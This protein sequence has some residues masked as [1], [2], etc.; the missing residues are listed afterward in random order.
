MQCMHLTYRALDGD[1]VPNVV[2]PQLRN[3]LSQIKKPRTSSLSSGPSVALLPSSTSSTPANASSST[4][5][6]ATATAWVVSSEDQR[7]YEI[8]FRQL[9]ADGKQ[10]VSGEDVKS[11]F[12]STGLPGNILAH[13]WSLCD[14]N[15]NGN[16]TAEQFM[17][18]MHLAKQKRVSNKVVVQHCL[19]VDSTVLRL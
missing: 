7:Q 9:D 11:L 8:L 15:G 10:C 1:P 16:L 14:M 12:M 3:Q 13:I 5:P 18:A 4:S 19:A 17:L 2:S 6:T